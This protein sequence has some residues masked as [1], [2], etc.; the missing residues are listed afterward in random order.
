MPHPVASSSHALHASSKNQASPSASRRCATL[1]AEISVASCVPYSLALGCVP[2]FSS[3]KI[4]YAA[5]TSA[6]STTHSVRSSV[7]GCSSP[8]TPSANCA[9]CPSVSHAGSSSREQRRLSAVR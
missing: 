3:S 1:Y 8:R 4:E 7:F 2:G 9:W 5:K 6:T